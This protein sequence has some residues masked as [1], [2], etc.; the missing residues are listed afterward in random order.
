MPL[1]H[2]GQMACAAI[3]LAFPLGQRVTLIAES[4]FP[5]AG[6][7]RPVGDNREV[8]GSD[9]AAMRARRGGKSAY[10]RVV[11]QVVDSHTVRDGASRCEHGY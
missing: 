10:K 4:G 5:A 8:L 9:T 1:A 2:V 7:V 6:N 11:T 3:P